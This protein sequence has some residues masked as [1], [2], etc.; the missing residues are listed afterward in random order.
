MVGPLWHEVPLS[1]FPLWHEAS[2]SNLQI[3]KWFVS[4]PESLVAH[5]LSSGKLTNNIR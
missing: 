1:D 2:L 5:Y 4:C 3:I